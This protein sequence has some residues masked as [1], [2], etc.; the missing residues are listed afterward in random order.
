MYRCSDPV[1]YKENLAATAN[2]WLTARRTT[3]SANGTSCVWIAGRS[4]AESRSSTCREGPSCP[5]SA[6]AESASPSASGVHSLVDLLQALLVSHA[7]ALLFVDNE[8]S[9]FFEND[10]L[11][12]EAMRADQDVDLAGFK[13]SSIAFCSLVRKRLSIS[14]RTGIPR[15]AQ[16]GVQVLQRENVVGTRSAT[17]LPSI[18]ALKAARSRPPSCRSRHRRKEAGPSAAAFHVAF[19]LLDRRP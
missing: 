19:D 1:L 4:S 2:A 16:E 14:T 17:C 12:Q 10:I 8:Q 18:T 6:S 13:S 9:E 15:S 3:P 5:Y 7:E 11:R